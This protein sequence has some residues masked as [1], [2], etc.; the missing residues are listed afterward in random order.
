MYT[1]PPSPDGEAAPGA[2]RGDYALFGH[3]VYQRPALDGRLYW[4]STETATR[5]PGHIEGALEAAERVTTAIL[6]NVG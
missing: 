4:C 2:N 5:S 1:S 6:S 3:P